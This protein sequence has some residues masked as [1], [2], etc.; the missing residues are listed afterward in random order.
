MIFQAAVVNGRE[1]YFCK[2][3]SKA[4]LSAYIGNL[5]TEWV[6]VDLPDGVQFIPGCPSFGKAE[7]MIYDTDSA[8]PCVDT[9]GTLKKSCLAG[10]QGTLFLGAKSAHLQKTDRYSLIATEN[11]M[12][13]HGEFAGRN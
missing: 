10:N 5:P 8:L 6:E 9:G 4:D 13:L 7:A 2:P 3:G 11:R 1:V 12:K